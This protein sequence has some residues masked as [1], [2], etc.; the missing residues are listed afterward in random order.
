MSVKLE[1]KLR[2][3]KIKNKLQVLGRRNSKMAPK[4]A[5]KTSKTP[6]KK[7]QNRD[8]LS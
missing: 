7:N 6:A 1:E 2:N 4:K 8:L 5:A 3:R